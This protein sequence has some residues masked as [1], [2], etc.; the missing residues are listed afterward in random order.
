MRAQIRKVSAACA[1]TVGVGIL[2]AAVP[3]SAAVSHVYTGSYAA[4]GSTP[5]NPYPVSGPTD[6]EVDQASNDF[7]V[8]DPA[9]H[10]VEKFDSAGNFILMFGKGVDQT[11]GDDVCTAASGDTCQT[12]TSSSEPGGFQTPT[13]LAVD[14]SGGPS[15]GDIY[16]ADTAANLVSK[17]D[18]TGHI[19]SAWG[20]AGQ[21]DGSD[22][23]LTS[24]L[25]AGG[26]TS[27]AVGGPNGDLYVGTPFYYEGENQSVLRY[28]P[29]GIYE[30]PYLPICGAPWLKV[31]PA[32]DIFTVGNG[33]CAPSNT[34]EE[35]TSLGGAYTTDSPTRGFGLDPS[36]GEIYQAVGALENSGT[37]NHGPRID[38]YGPDCN[39]TNPICEPADTF[40]ETQL[41][42]A[43]PM[44]VAVDGS[45]HT[46][47]VA[48]SN[49]ND[50]AVFGDAQPIITPTPPIP[51]ESSVTLTAHIDPAGRGAITSCHFEYGFDKSYGTTVPCTPDPD[52]SPPGSNFTTPTDVT[53]TI[54]GLSPGTRD[55]Y[56]VVVSNSA[57]ATS[58]GPDQTFIT[59]Q[60][61]AVDGLAS[62]NL[63]ATSADLNAQLNPDGL[64]TTYRFEYGPT[65]AYGQSTP[66]PDGSLSASNE[67]QA[68]GV[69]LSN[70]TPHVVYHYRSSP[71]TLTAPRRHRITPSTSFHPAAPTKMSA[72]RP[73][74]TTFPTAAPTSSS[75]PVTPAVPSSTPAGPTR[76]MRPIPLASPSPASGRR[77]RAPAGTRSTPSATST[78]PPAPTPAG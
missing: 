24:F 39:P 13:Y 7:Y 34:V 59:T 76:A 19:V 32:G 1:L 75:H 28:M 10:R 72:S 16:V 35:E 20:K 15:K 9:D 40:G 64:D 12:G 53:A 41:A 56:R 25:A 54:T 31:D 22:T 37:A 42:T 38:H 21:K 18:S 66:V 47:Y 71:P 17:F 44:G 14:N 73:R 50:V 26:I 49:S 58:V 67:D 61:P 3:A 30:G 5:A 51:T 63:T 2:I 43:G 11:T 4:A 6:V 62:A 57:D 23:E 78:S 69:H 45:S 60:P 27:L 65:T 46:V 68:I 70:L 33:R 48:D 8:T 77:S 52:S 36:S 29:G 55:H 74:P